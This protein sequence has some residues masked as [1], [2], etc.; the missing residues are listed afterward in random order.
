MVGNT[1]NLEKYLIFDTM[2]V[3]LS[4]KSEQSRNSALFQLQ[5]SLDK[6]TGSEQLN[7]STKIAPTYPKAI[8][9]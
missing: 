4:F 2:I 5:V 3:N 9:R 6:E 7:V 8:E 1:K